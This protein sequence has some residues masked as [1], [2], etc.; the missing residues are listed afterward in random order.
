MT[1]RAT[2]LATADTSTRTADPDGHPRPELDL[3]PPLA[4]GRYPGPPKD[5]Q[6]SAKGPSYRSGPS[7]MRS[8]A[9]L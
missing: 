4:K 7:V 2:K 8:T 3:A 6:H 9:E 1:Q 5:S